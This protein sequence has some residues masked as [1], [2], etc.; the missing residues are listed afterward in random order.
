MT[1]TDQR[2]K[3]IRAASSPDLHSSI[4]KRS[5]RQTKLEKLCWP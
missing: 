3:E 1:V 4:L 2:W 5:T